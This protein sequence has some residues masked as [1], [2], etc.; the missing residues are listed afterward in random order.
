MLTDDR[1]RVGLRLWVGETALAGRAAQVSGSELDG[2]GTP[3]DETAEQRIQGHRFRV[4][5]IGMVVQRFGVQ[6]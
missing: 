4:R 3:R 1:E 2:S 6:R 5:C